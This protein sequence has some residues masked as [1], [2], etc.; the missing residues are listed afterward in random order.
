MFMFQKSNL[1]PAFAYARWP[2]TALAA[3][4]L[5]GCALAPGLSI[6]KGLQVSESSA[7]PYSITTK[8]GPAN[9]GAPGLG[10][11]AVPGQTAPPGALLAITP[12][13]INQQRALQKA[14]LGNDVKSLFAEAKAYDIGPGDV[15]NIV[16]WNHPELVLAPA[17]AT[18][19]TDRKSTRLNSSHS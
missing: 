18:L 19:T 11:E 14:E 1:T 4:W 13:L 16:V 3:V 17:G 2:V 10:N 9:P 15:I 8:R 12:E 6:G 7:N 5:S